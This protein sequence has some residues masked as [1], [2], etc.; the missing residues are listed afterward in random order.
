MDALARRSHIKTTPNPDERLDYVITLTGTLGFRAAESSCQ[1]SIRYIPDKLI[2]SQASF[3][4]YLDAVGEVEWANLEEAAT[5]ML[6]DMGNEVVARWMQIKAVLSEDGGGTAA[7]SHQI[8]LEDKQPQWD[9][10][11][12]LARLAVI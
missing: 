11:S 7:L 6:E 1:F 2:I 10:A 3:A 4:A 5:A 12:L 9:N 8:V